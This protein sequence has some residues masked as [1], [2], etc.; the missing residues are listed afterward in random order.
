MNKTTTALNVLYKKWAKEESAEI[1]QIAE[2]GS[3]R[4][5]FRI[6]GKEKSAIGVFNH[7]K[8]ENRSFLSFSRHFLKKDLNVP[9]IYTQDLNKNIYL[10]QDLGD[11]TLFTFAQKN[12]KMEVIRV[13]KSALAHLVKFQIDGGKGL[14]YSVC[15]PREKFDKQSILWDLNYFKYYFLKLAKIPFDEQKLELDF[16]T[17]T[18]LLLQSESNYFLYR[19][20]QARNILLHNDDLFFIDYQGGRK[21]A[22][23]YDVASLLFQAQINLSPAERNELLSYYLDKLQKKIKIKKRDFSKHYYN[24][25][26]IR[27]LQTFGAYGFRGFFENKTYF[28]KSIP[29]ALNN[30]AWM[31]KNEFIPNKLKELQKVLTAIIQNEELIKFRSKESKKLKVVIHS[32]SYKK[33]LPIDYSGNGGGFVFDCRVLDNPGRYAEYSNL[34]GKDEGVVYFL[35]TKSKANEFLSSVYTLVDDAVKNY[36]ERS[37]TNLMVNFGCTGGQHRSVYCAERLA[38][39]LNDNFNVQVELKHTQ[40][41]KEGL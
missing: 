26:L 2:S 20:F 37:F 31:I 27:L 15:Y 17:F 10:L 30:L 23:Q 8:N 32:F 25:A 28:I 5:Y 3:Y 39:H 38:N 21:G 36:N 13:Y 22:L 40:L 9:K 1:K 16:K 12:K 14:D 7:D 33:G 35:E 29:F 19:D 41:S 6:K 11:E 4:K 18:N 34:T 24:Y